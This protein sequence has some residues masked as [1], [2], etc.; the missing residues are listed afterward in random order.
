MNKAKFI[1]FASV[2]SEI[3]QSDLFMTVKARILESPKANLNGTAVT[4]A[5]VDGVIANEERYVGLPLY[6]DIHALRNGKYNRLGHLY[7]SRTGEFHSTQIGSFYQFEKEEFE[8]GCYL[9]GYARIPKRDKSLSKAIAELFADGALKFSFEIACVDYET[10]EDGV[11]VIDASENNYLEG[12]AIV[13]FPACEDAVALEFVA[14]RKADDTQRGDEEMADVEKLVAEET[15]ATATE[16]VET[17]Q[18]ET[19]TETVEPV[20]TAEKACIDKKAADEDPEKEPEEAPE[21]EKKPEEESTACKDKKACIDKKAEATEDA[22]CKKEQAEVFVHEDHYESH[23]VNMHDAE[24]G[25][26]YHQTITVDTS[27]CQTVEGNVVEADEGISIAEETDTPQ[28]PGQETP[29]ETPPETPAQPETPVQPETPAASE[30][31]DN[32]V[33]EDAPILPGE[34]KKTAEELIAELTQTVMSLAEEVKSL[35]EQHVAASV[36]TAEVNP[37]TDTITPQGNGYSLL[38]PVS[39]LD[40]YTLI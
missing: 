1:S 7:D 31:Q 14:Q 23:S 15:E 36:V 39:K 33:V 12:T 40:H 8:G 35:K 16:A 34:T 32:P 11:F 19:T 38:E 3:Q 6:A 2:I 17:A 30:T 10:N 4:E 13:T 25:K 28:D 37:F 9:V 27:V 20:E 5:F 29:T 18:V 21:E 26:D 22:E 24:S